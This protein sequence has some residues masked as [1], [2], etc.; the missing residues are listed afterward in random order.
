[1]RRKIIFSFWNAD[2]LTWA[3]VVWGNAKPKIN[4]KYSADKLIGRFESVTKDKIVRIFEIL[5]LQ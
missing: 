4:N 1:M 3:D 2:W 5:N